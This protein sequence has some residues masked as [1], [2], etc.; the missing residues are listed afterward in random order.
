MTD[1][2]SGRTPLY[3]A[4]HAPRHERQALI[5][6]Y[7]ET[8]SCRHV[9]MVDYLFSHSITLSEETLYDANPDENLHV[10]RCRLD[11]KR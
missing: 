3:E 1:P 7:Q 11:R 6:D 10:M 8:Y 4:H 2:A 9:V 5:R